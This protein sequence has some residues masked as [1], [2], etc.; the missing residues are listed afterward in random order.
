MYTLTSLFVLLLASPVPGVAQSVEPM[1]LTSNVIEGGAGGSDDL[2][3]AFTAGAG[4]VVVTAETVFVA[5]AADATLAVEFLGVDEEGIATT[6]AGEM[7]GQGRRRVEEALR[8]GVV[9]LLPVSAAR[10]PVRRR[11]KVT[12]N[13]A[14]SQT[15]LLHVRAGAGLSSFRLRLD[16]PIEYATPEEPPADTSAGLAGPP[17]PEVMSEDEWLAAEANASTDAPEEEID[18]PVEAL[19]SSSAPGVPPAAKDAKPSIRIPGR[20][21]TVVKVPGKATAATAMNVPAKSTGTAKPA[22]IRIPS[23]V[24]AKSGSAPAPRIRKSAAKSPLNVLVIRPKG[25]LK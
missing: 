11:T 20:A 5:D 17:Q 19:A 1:P 25:D 2:Y 9:E 15:L 10:A 12:A 8:R 21:S 22:P 14:E 3:F 23:R 24:A 7:I 4:D 16:G 18:I 6:L 13:L